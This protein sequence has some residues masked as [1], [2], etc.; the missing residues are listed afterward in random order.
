MSQPGGLEAHG[1]QYLNAAV[2][3]FVIWNIQIWKGSLHCHPFKCRMLQCYNV[4][5]LETLCHCIPFE[6]K[7]GSILITQECISVS[8]H[9]W[10]A[11]WQQSDSQE[12][13][14]GAESFHAAANDFGRIWH[15][16]AHLTSWYKSDTEIAWNRYHQTSFEKKRECDDRFT[17]F[18]VIP[19]HPSP[20][21]S[22]WPLKFQVIWGERNKDKEIENSM[23][24][25]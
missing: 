13:P 5:A 9:R 20:P 19:L 16:A 14:C 17:D 10:V 3:R 4:H 15:S 6:F 23:K 25:A 7:A 21:P 2:Q 8:T 11:I 12:T 18:Q 22:S 24:I 1:P